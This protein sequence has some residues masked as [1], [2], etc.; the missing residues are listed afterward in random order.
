[1]T[2]ASRFG[3]TK[4]GL[5]TALFV[6]GVAVLLA[7]V[8]LRTRE[9]DFV[10]DWIYPGSSPVTGMTNGD[11][12]HSV[13][14]TTDRFTNV[15]D[16]YSSQLGMGRGGN[17]MFM[18]R[19]RGF[20]IHRNLEQIG[21]MGDQSG[22]NAATETFLVRRQE[23]AVIIHVSWKGENGSTWIS[24]STRELQ[25][26][27]TSPVSA[28]SLVAALTP[29]SSLQNAGGQMF[30][31]AANAL[32]DTNPFA[33]LARLW[34]DP[35]SFTTKFAGV[36]GAGELHRAQVLRLPVAEPANAR[37]ADLLFVT[38]NSCSFIHLAERSNQTSQL[39]IGSMTR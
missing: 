22:T 2:N 9:T 18:G 11:V 28:L 27:T 39:L 5:V 37:E 17:P 12:L 19:S 16:W 4:A 20:F 36:I 31:I 13:Y 38:P 33:R 3:L 15:V 34:D 10:R 6:T 14:A 23:R 32:T 25:P 26:S 21:R 7:I 30:N 29:S 24:L 1:M 8:A 35:V